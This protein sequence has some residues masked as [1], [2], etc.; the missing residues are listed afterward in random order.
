MTAAIHLDG[1]SKSFGS[2]TVL[3]E[4]TLE[5]EEG[6]AFCLLGRSGTGK[7]V[8]LRHIIGLVR[9][10]SGRVFVEDRDITTLGRRPAPRLT[11]VP[12]HGRPS[13]GPRC[14][15]SRLSTRARSS[16]RASG[17]NWGWRRRLKT[18]MISTL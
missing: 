16:T 2:L 4:V 10:D 9:A 8:A 11:S 12:N 5:V 1:V 17:S 7:S 18:L 14:R 13:P 6:T 15:E 3:D